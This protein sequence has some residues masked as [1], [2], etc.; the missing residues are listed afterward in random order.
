M[1]IEL[2]PLLIGTFGLSGAAL[3]TLATGAAG[4]GASIY[5]ANKQA[6][7]VKAAS[8]E[9]AAAQDRQNA[10]AW[11]NYLMTRG[12]NPAGAQTG[13]IPANPQAINAKL[14]L[15]A[16]ANFRR[17]GAQPRWVKRGTSTM[18]NTLS[19]GTVTPTSP[20]APSFT[21]SAAGGRGGG[22]RIEGESSYLQ[23]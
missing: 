6:K 8:A 3:A 9:N 5:G 22:G 12:V 4:I 21:G 19:R 13:Q 20:Y 15:W 2:F 23:L 18:P 17:P 16:T 1:T 10:S 7:A 14:P 11:A